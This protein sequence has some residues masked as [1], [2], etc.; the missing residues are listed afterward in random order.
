MPLSILHP[1]IDAFDASIRDGTSW[2]RESL[3]QLQKPVI[4]ATLHQAV[5]NLATYEI[6]QSIANAIADK[7]TE[8]RSFVCSEGCIVNVTAHFVEVTYT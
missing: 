2:S 5:G 4:A 7:N 1:A 6:I 8:P 3:C